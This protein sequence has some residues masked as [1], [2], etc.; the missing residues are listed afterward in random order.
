MK[1]VSKLGKPIRVFVADANAMTCQLMVRALKQSR[2]PIEVAG[3]AT[4]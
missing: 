2:E 4:K 1:S 3:Y